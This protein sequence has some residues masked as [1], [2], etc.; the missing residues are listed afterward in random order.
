MA[1]SM[2]QLI[3]VPLM[4][5]CGARVGETHTPGG[6]WSARFMTALWPSGRAGSALREEVG[7]CRVGGNMPH[8]H[9]SG[10]LN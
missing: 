9:L 2:S 3:G 1:H 10:R 6:W 7:R 4:Q 8:R 5:T